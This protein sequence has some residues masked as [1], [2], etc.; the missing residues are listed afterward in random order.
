MERLTERNKYGVPIVREDLPRGQETTIV[1][2]LAAYEDSGID[3]EMVAVIGWIGKP[4]WI[5]LSTAQSR[6]LF[7]A[8]GKV[9]QVFFGGR[10]TPKVEVMVGLTPYSDLEPENVF[11][12]MDEAEAALAEMEERRAG[13]M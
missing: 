12:S 7:V 6:K 11:L 10:I 13:Q 3:P 5:I 1:S 8:G 2:R 9:T 4:A